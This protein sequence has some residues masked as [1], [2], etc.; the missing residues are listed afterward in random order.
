TNDIVQ[1]IAPYGTNAHSTLSN[2]EQAYVTAIVPVGSGLTIDA[3]KFVTLMGFE[4]IETNANWN[5]SRSLLFSYAIPYFHTGLRLTYSPMDNFSVSVH[6]VNGWNTVIDN[7]SSKSVGL[8]LNYSINSN[9]I[10]TING[11]SGFEQA[12]VGVPVPVKYGKKNLVELITIH[13]I[14][15]RLQLAL[16]ADYGEERVAGLLNIWKGLAMYCKYLANGNSYFAVRGEIFYDPNSYTTATTFSGATFKE[17]TIT[18]DYNLFNNLSVY[19][20]FR[21]DIANGYAFVSSDPILPA[22]STQP[23]LLL[24]VVSNF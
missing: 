6:V 19:T 18:Y 9:T 8:A 10:I 1:G 7:N 5:Y 23:T 15:S 12:R 22:K 16:D 3:G 14:T 11:M 2:L 20:E 24:G 4:V 21:D 17:V 13:Q